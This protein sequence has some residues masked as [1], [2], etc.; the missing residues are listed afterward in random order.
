MWTSYNVTEN[1]PCNP[2]IDCNTFKNNNEAKYGKK[3]GSLPSELLL[4]DPQVLNPC[5]PAKLGKNGDCELSEFSKAE[6]DAMWKILA[7]AMT[8]EERKPLDE[9]IA[10]KK[11]EKEVQIFSRKELHLGIHFTPGRGRI[12]H[13]YDTD[14]GFGMNFGADLNV[15]F[16]ETMDLKTGLN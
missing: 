2:N 3:I 12:S 11:E 13:V 10:P 8:P 14:N 4:E 15:Y 9:I 16:D 7:T 5:K 6:F 1:K